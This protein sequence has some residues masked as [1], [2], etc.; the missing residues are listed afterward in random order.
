M[1]IKYETNKYEPEI[2]EIEI[3]DSKNVFLQGKNMWDNT[4]TYFG[5]W[6]KESSLTIVT[7]ISYRT[8]NYKHYLTTSLST[9]EYIK[10]Y[11]KYNNDVKVILK[12]EFEE[13]INHIR[14]ILKV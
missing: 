7:I 3:K 9:V 14:L 12:E 8:I 10:E 4:D 13:Q 2:Q 5:I 6:K 11:L 1:I